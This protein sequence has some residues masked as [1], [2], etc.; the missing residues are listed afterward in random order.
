MMICSFGATGPH[1]QRERSAHQQTSV[2]WSVRGGYSLY[3][4]V[5]KAVAFAHKW[6]ILPQSSWDFTPDSLL[7]C[8]RSPVMTNTR[9]SR[10]LIG[11]C[12]FDRPDNARPRDNSSRQTFVCFVLFFCQNTRRVFCQ[13]RFCV[14]FNLNCGRTAAPLLNQPVYLAVV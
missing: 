10:K 3:L 13:V 6:Q 4:G 1:N 9:S 12:G 8:L 2:L 7:F 5:N 11:G 14:M